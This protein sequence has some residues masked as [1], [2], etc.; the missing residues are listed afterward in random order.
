MRFRLA[1]FDWNGTLL[2]DLPA[3]YGAVVHIFQ[4]VSPNLEP[5]TLEE[6]CNEITSK[7]MDFYYAH[8]I[9][10]SVSGD[11]LNNIR[12]PYYEEHSRTAKL[13]DGAREFLARCQELGL[14]NAMVSASPEDVEKTLAEFGVANLFDKIR[15][16]AWPKDAALRETVEYFGIRPEEAFYVDDTFDGITSAKNLG[17]WTIGFTGGYNTR[18]RILAA[19]PNYAVDS[20]RHAIA[21]LNSWEVK[22]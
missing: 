11:D 1:I 20:L 18:E 21:I 5:P 13:N 10:T 14:K 17:L 3:A 22:P 19:R 16:K 2:N 12:K 8:G 7:F 15:L 6:Y 9:P 4:T